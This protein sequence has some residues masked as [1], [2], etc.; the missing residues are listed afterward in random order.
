MGFPIVKRCFAIALT[1]ILSFISFG[2][3]PLVEQNMSVSAT[4]NE[5]VINEAGTWYETAFAV[6]TGDINSKYEVYVKGKNIIDWRDGSPINDFLTDWTLVNNEAN[7]PLVRV[8]DPIRST[9]RADIPGLPE[10]VYEIQVRLDGKVEHSFSNLETKAF[11]VM[12]R[13]SYH[14]MKIHT[15]GIIILL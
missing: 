5:N 6:W 2:I 4:S 1:V 14:Q 15:K 9:W 10:G 7:A 3:V 11:H 12:V 13:L 8:V